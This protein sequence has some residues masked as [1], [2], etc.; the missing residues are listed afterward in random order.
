MRE[1]VLHPFERVAQKSDL[2]IVLDPRQRRTE[3]T[4]CH[5]ISRLCQ[6]VQW[7]GGPLDDKATYNACHQ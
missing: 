4:L 1:R 2:V 7:S 3:I 6:L 5:L